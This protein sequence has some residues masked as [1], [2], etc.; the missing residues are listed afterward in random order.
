ML[1]LSCDSVALRS[2]VNYAPKLPLNYP[3]DVRIKQG[4]VRRHGIGLQN[5]LR[6]SKKR[7]EFT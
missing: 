7:F 4:S 3:M 5:N 6:F 1:S 2:S